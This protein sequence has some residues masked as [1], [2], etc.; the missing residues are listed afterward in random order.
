MLIYVYRKG[1]NNITYAILLL[2]PL[3]EAFILIL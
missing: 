3:E 1:Y 2:S